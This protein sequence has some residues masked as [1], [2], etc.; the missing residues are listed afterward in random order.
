MFD[1]I[2]WCLS[3]NNGTLIARRNGYVFITQNTHQQ[4]KAIHSGKLLI[5][6]GAL[7]GYLPYEYQDD[8]K[9]K[10][11]INGYAVIY[12]DSKGNTN[13]SKSNFIHLGSRVPT[14]KKILF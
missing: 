14:K 6:Q 10:S 2:V 1:W 5:E 3:V 7:C 11:A 9:F 4:I 13:F 8:L 12:Q